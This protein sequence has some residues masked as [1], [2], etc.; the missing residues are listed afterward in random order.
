LNADQLIESYV[1]DVAKLLPRAQRAD[2]AH[3]LRTLLRDELADR[4]GAAGRGPDEETVRDLLDGFGRPA[5]VAARYR[6]AMILIDPADSRR[7]LRISA[8]GMA[9]IWLLGLLDVIGGRPIDSL[10]GT[11]YALSTWWFEVAIPSLWWPG[12]VFAFFATASWTHRRWPATA[13]WKPKPVDRD[14]ISR[15]GVG[16]ALVFFVCGTLVLLNPT[17]VIDGLIGGRMPVGALAYDHDFYHQRAP[18]LL[19][20]MVT[21]LALYVVLLVQGRWHSLTRRIDVGLSLAICGVLTWILLVGDIFVGRPADQTV[22]GVIVLIMVS[23]LIDVSQK[24]RLERRR[25]MY[26]PGPSSA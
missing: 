6:P 18:W 9:V 24:L 5:D 3:E 1:S 12:V 25:S 16:A 14:R 10:D 22:K 21:H 19:A 7:V 17:W 13:R 23:A 20:L 2:V 11:L 4:T 8:I 26:A 15:I